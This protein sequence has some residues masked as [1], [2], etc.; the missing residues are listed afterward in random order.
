M[1]NNITVEI[2]KDLISINEYDYTLVCWSAE[3]WQEDAEV[4]ISIANAINLA[5]TD[6]KQLKELLNIS[7]D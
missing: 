1:S 2:T 6:L 5:H 7:I 4:V 3:E